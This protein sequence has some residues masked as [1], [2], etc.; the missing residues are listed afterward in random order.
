MTEAL[1]IGG[2]PAG[3]AAAFHL[4]QAGAS[5]VVLERTT[6]PTDKVC[7]DFLSVEAATEL[8]R[9]GLDLDRLG[10]ARITRLRVIHGRRIA[11]TDLPFTARGLSRRILDE[12]LLVRA[13]ETGAR[14]RR[15]VVA[16]ALRAD[17]GGFVCRTQTGEEQAGTVFLAT[18]KHDLRGMPRSFSQSLGL[19]TYVTLA[20]EQIADLHG[21]V[22]LT[23]FRGGHLGMQ[24]VE[25]GDVV[26]CAMVEKW[27]FAAAG[28]SWPAL[29][30]TV[31]D[32]CSHLRSRLAGSVACRERPVAVAGVPYGHVHRTSLSADPFRL[33][34]QA[35]VIPSL[36]GDGIALALH[37]AR[38]A[39]QTWLSGGRPEAHHEAFASRV[40]GQ[41]RAAVALHRLLLGPGAG[42]ATALASVAPGLLREAARLTR[43]RGSLEP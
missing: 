28:G 12:A 30:E 35:C 43:L 9:F 16:R 13:I 23:L 15:G 39:T 40:A 34:D 25:G 41:M 14:V 29:L 36:T 17:G 37:G 38:L 19:K 22:E 3:A 1:I 32:G 21:H 18:G 2:G 7:G 11:A 27:R 4:A 10:A 20:P 42:W 33:G 31:T 6:G 8:T 24:P 26:L 5:P